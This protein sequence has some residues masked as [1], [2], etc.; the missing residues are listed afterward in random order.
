MNASTTTMNS[1]RKILNKPETDRVTTKVEE[2][3]KAL[4]NIGFLGLA[5]AGVVLSAGL[6]FFSKKQEL[7]SFVGL[8][9]PTILLLGLY[10]KLVQV[11]D[12]MLSSQGIH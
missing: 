8:W 7:G 6:T 1:G 11:E 4:P 3:A 5:G 2:Q 10:N 9:V 12:E